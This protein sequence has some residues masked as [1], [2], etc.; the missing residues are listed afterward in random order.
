[1][2]GQRRD[3]R[4]S[5]KTKTYRVDLH[6][7]LVALLRTSGCPDPE[8]YTEERDQ[9]L[10]QGKEEA[11]AHLQAVL[12]TRP[13]VDA[14]EVGGAKLHASSRDSVKI[15]T[16]VDE[17]VVTLA[18]SNG[19]LEAEV[20]DGRSSVRNRCRGAREVVFP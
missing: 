12:L 9:L 16:D 2:K 10:L 13:S 11:K 19:R 7:E 3:R 15:L 18:E 20:A 1:V 6:R 4:E 14:G 8:L 5:S 17:G